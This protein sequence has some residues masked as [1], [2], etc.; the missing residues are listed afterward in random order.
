MVGA[1]IYLLSAFV[2]PKFLRYAGLLLGL[3]NS[4]KLSMNRRAYIRA[5]PLIIYIVIAIGYA[6][7][8]K[9]HLYAAVELSICILIAT[10]L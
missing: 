1:L 8:V 9:L 2:T 10:I 7:D 6:R 3:F 5:L 4:L